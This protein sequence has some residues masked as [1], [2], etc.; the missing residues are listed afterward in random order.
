MNYLCSPKVLK[1]LLIACKQRASIFRIHALIIHKGLL[2]QCASS[3]LG[4]CL[5]MCY[6]RLGDV[7]SACLMF[8]QMPRRG[9]DS[10]NALINSYSRQGC[11][12]QVLRL[13]QSMISEGIM[14]D[15]STFTLTI[16]ACTV[17]NDL[18]KGEEVWRK[19]V[20]CGYEADIFVGSSVLNLYAKIGVMDKAL[21]FFNNMRRRD[22]VCWTTMVTGFAWSKKP[23]EA[24]EM[25]QRMQR[26]GIEG[27][28]VVIVGLIH[29]CSCLG[30]LKP[31]RSVH[32]YLIRKWFPTKTS[33]QIQTGL[34]DMYSKH[35]HPEIASTVFRYMPHKNNPISWAA[36]VSGFA[37]NGFTQNALQLVMDMQIIGVELNSAC[38]VSALSACSQDG[39][40][41]LGRSIHGYILRR[42]DLDLILG[43]A[44]IDFYSKCGALILARTLFDSLSFKDSVSWNTMI[45]CYGTH[46]LGKEALSIFLQ[47]IQTYEKPDHITF[48]SLLSAL[49]HSGLIEEGQHWFN[50]MQSDYKIKPAEKHYACIVDLLSRAGK[51]KEAL[52][53]IFS[54]ATEPGLAVWGALLSGCYNHGEFIIGEVAAN[55]IIDLGPDDLGIYSLVSNFF[56]KEKKWVEVAQVRKMMK[57]SLTKKIPGYS[58]VDVNGRLH[59]FIMEDKSH[60]QHRDIEQVLNLLSTEIRVVKGDPIPEISA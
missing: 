36:L 53:M 35:G 39:L 55:K 29:A 14:P 25:F 17:L 7:A 58:V 32:G 28:G 40:L 12:E 43:T 56:A 4:G 54:I 44:L 10:W 60:E 6:A 30:V 38:L 37:Q 46:G 9:V 24:I 27:D 26:E 49:S 42:D 16:K 5:V 57:E 41:R 33:V 59:A 1:R 2:N 51:L 52:E 15:S 13:Y 22:I 11:P 8:D 23:G 34:I 45:A 3:S 47:M 21:S 31:G 19:S 50:L 18:E 48:F 20:E